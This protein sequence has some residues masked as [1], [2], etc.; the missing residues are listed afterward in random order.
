MSRWVSLVNMPLFLCCAQVAKP[1]HEEPRIHAFYII[2]A[3]L[4]QRK[5]KVT[6]GDYPDLVSF[7]KTKSN[8]SERGDPSIQHIPFLSSLLFIIFH[9]D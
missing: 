6:P 2:S 8:P 4:P 5:V 9:E 1:L 3:D 7:E